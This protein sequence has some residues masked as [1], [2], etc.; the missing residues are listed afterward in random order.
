MLQA[1]RGLCFLL[2]VEDRND[3]QPYNKRV[4]FGNKTL[5]FP[6]LHNASLRGDD[7]PLEQGP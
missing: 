4:D 6:C 5:V 2:K 1:A 7:V 3:E